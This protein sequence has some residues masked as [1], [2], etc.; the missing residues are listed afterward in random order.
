MEWGAT[1]VYPRR[2][3]QALGGAVRGGPPCCWGSIT[4]PPPLPSSSSPPNPKGARLPA[5]FTSSSRLILPPSL[6]SPAITQFLHAGYT[7][8][9]VVD[10]CVCMT[11]LC[12][13]VLVLALRVCRCDALCLCM[14]CHVCVCVYAFVTMCVCLFECICDA[15]RTFVM[16][17]VCVPV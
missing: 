15:V 8:R 4:P 11:R 7:G 17:S 12:D 13:S 14:C 6:L 3:S 9:A 16:H 2:G 5:L 1:T 10:V